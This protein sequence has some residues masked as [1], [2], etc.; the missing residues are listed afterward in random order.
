MVF[1]A[2]TSVIVCPSQ[3]VNISPY[4]NSLYVQKN[5]SSR[6]NPLTHPDLLFVLLDPRSCIRAYAKIAYAEDCLHAQS[7]CIKLRMHENFNWLQY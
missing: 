2:T 5:L 6:E 7:K 1:K 4:L 3:N